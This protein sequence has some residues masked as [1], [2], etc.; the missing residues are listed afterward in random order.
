MAFGLDVFYKINTNS[1]LITLITQS[2]CENKIVEE[3]K[4]TKTKAGGGAVA[5]IIAYSS[6]RHRLQSGGATRD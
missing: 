2:A 3:N 5:R 4:H 1:D 6:A